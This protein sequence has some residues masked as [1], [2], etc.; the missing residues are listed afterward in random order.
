MNYRAE[1]DVMRQ[2]ARATKL[3][4]WSVI[5]ALLEEQRLRGNSSVIRGFRDARIERGEETS[6]LPPLDKPNVLTIHDLPSLEGIEII[7]NGEGSI[8]RWTRDGVDPERK[9]DRLPIGGRRERSRRKRR[10]A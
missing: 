4:D 7:G 2:I 1:Q 8:R 6:G 3:R 9:N 10:A 5:D